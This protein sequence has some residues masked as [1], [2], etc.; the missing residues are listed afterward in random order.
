M[1]A[2]RDS[3]WVTRIQSGISRTSAADAPAARS[4]LEP[5]LKGVFVEGDKLRVADSELFLSLGE[6]HEPT[7]SPKASARPGLRTG[8]EVQPPF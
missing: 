3:A 2:C 1:P 7:S 5:F 6:S 4:P 8:A